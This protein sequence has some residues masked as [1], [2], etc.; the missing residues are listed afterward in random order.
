MSSPR[1]LN[2]CTASP[3][4]LFYSILFCFESYQ[5]QNV[6]HII[7][8]S[9]TKSSFNHQIIKIVARTKFKSK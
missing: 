2:N 4:F 7:P 6:F 1:S 5:G 3:F 9:N 8:I